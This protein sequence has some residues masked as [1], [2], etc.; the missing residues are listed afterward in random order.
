MNLIGR[1]QKVSD[2]YCAKVDLRRE[3]VSYRIFADQRRM[4]LVF[5]GESGLTVANYEKAMLWFASNWPEA[6]PWPEGVERPELDDEPR[7]VAET[8]GAAA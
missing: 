2:A 6:L 7:Q 4:G 3:Q 1:L 8:A 5:G